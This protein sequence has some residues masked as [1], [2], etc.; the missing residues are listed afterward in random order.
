VIACGVEKRR[1]A[2]LQN[3]HGKLSLRKPI[4]V[5]YK[6]YDLIVDKGSNTLTADFHS[7]LLSATKP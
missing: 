4:A 5:L 6:R 2:L 3:A 7:S 1:H